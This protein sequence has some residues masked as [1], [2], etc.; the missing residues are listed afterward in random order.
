[1]TRFPVDVL[2]RDLSMTTS[3]ANGEFDCVINAK[4]VIKRNYV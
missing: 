2:V 4:S 1:M 3:T